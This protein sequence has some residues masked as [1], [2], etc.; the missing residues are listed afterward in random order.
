[1]LEQLECGFEFPVIG[2]RVEGW[3]LKVTIPSATSSSSRG[4]SSTFERHSSSWRHVVRRGC[5]TKTDS[6]RA[7]QTGIAMGEL[8]ANASGIGTCV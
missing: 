2:I 8:M 4:S 6:R 7:E 5:V 3:F 1:M